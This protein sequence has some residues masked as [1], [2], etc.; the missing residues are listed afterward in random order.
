MVHKRLL[1]RLGVML[2]FVV[3]VVVQQKITAAC[4]CDIYNTGGTPCVAAYSTVRALFSSYYGPLYQVIRAS[5]KTTLNIYPVDTGGVANSAV[6][7]SFL[8]GTTGEVSIIYDQS[9]EG[10]NVKRAP[11]GTEENYPDSLATASA[12]DTLNG[13]FA[14]GLYMNTKCGYRNDT[15]KGMPTGNK[16]QGIYEVVNGKH[17]GTAC[18]WDFGNA[19]TNNGAGA[20]GSMEAL[21][22]G[23]GYWGKGGGSGPWFMGDFEA[24]V[25]S[26]GSGA[27]GTTNTKDSSITYTYAVGMLKSSASNYA[28]KFGNAKSGHLNTAYSGTPP[29]V[30]KLQGAIVLGIGGD[31]SNSSDGTFYEGAITSGEPSDTTDSLVLQSIQAAGYGQMVT[32]TRPVKEMSP[33]SSFTVRYNPANSRATIAYVLRDTRRVSINIYNPQGRHVAEVADGVFS[34]GGHEAVWD[35]KRIPAGVYIWKLSIDRMAGATGRIAIGE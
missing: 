16:S 35:T 8:K 32:A 11:A 23:T 10:N 22:F 34:A 5:D 18:C 19:E 30:W 25:W 29:A 2:T 24:G 33:G 7:D 15:T 17:Y 3:F 13:Q 4:P 27:S 12:R 14:Y 26:G 1:S 9:G 20:T 21:F 31:N 28:I 6:Q